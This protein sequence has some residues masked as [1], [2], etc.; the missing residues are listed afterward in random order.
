MSKI[1]KVGNKIP[2]V[3][4]KAIK[5]RGV[6]IT[7]GI[8]VKARDADGYATEIDFY[9]ADGVVYIDSLNWTRN[10][11]GQTFKMLTSVKNKNTI[12][13]IKA[14]GMR[15][16]PDIPQS[17]MDSFLENV[18]TV[19]NGAFASCRF[20]GTINLPECTTFG[21]RSGGQGATFDSCKATAY[22]LPKATLVGWRVFYRCTSMLSCVLGSVGNT[23][24]IAGNPFDGATNPNLEIT[25]FTT[26]AYTDTALANARYGATNATIIIKA[27]EDTTYNGE[28]YLVGET[29]ITSTPT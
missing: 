17:E 3:D 9:S 6:E 10:D 25:I 12:T 13:E 1:I 14:N 23:V 29:I 20:T 19:G 15:S 8:V 7:D 4:D 21:G 18:V 16:F 11:G 2:L 22:V 24:E 28:T 5:S 27:S 26:G